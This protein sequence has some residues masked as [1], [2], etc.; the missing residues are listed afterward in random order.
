MYVALAVCVYV[1]MCVCTYVCSCVVVIL[2]FHVFV[3]VQTKQTLVFFF[4]CQ[5]KFMT[6]VL[7]FREAQKTRFVGCTQTLTVIC[8]DHIFK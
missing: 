1:F 4:F 6:E 2:Y 5:H 3:R 7:S 8:C